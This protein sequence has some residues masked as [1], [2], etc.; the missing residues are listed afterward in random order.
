MTGEAPASETKPS[1][2]TTSGADR[3]G[4]G[5]NKADDFAV[6]VKPEFVLT[7]R[8]PILTPDKP[9]N[10]VTPVSSDNGSGSGNGNDR[11]NNKKSRRGQNKKR[12]RDAKIA[13]EDKVCL[14]VVRGEECPFGAE[15]C[16]YNHDLKEI[17]ANRPEDID[18]IDGY[19][20]E[21]GC[22]AWRLRG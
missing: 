7:E 21:E 19:L 5:N 10:A 18:G 17:L 16:K 20:K 9:V 12:P 4:S 13:Q 3:N 1:A 8:S 2:E 22:P 14:A 11:R 6:K 15:K